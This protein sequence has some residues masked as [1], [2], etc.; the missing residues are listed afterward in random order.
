MKVLHLGCGRARVCFLK[1]HTRLVKGGG[2]Q[3]NAAGPGQLWWGVNIK[4]GEGFVFAIGCIPVMWPEKSKFAAAVVRS[5][6]GK[7]A[8]PNFDRMTSPVR[9]AYG[10][11]A[12]GGVEEGGLRLWVR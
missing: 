4:R 5:S 10:S 7:T 12:R 8:S 6:A 2:A 1:R 9:R 3:K 11:P